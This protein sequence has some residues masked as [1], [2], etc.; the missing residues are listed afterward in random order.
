MRQNHLFPRRAQRR[1]QYQYSGRTASHNQQV[2]QEKAPLVEL[3]SIQAF[4]PTLNVILHFHFEM[5][6]NV[7]HPTLLAALDEKRSTETIG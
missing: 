2:Q 6:E 5:P 1:V 7:T 4:K 3:F